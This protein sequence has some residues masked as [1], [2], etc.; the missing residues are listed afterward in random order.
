MTGRAYSNARVR[1]AFNLCSRILI[2]ALTLAGVVAAAASVDAA[3]VSL[4]WNAPTTNA[5]G[6]PLTDLANYRVYLATAAPSCPSPSFL[7]VS[8]PTSTP[9]A[10]QAVAS[11]VTALT[12]GVTYFARITAVDSTGNESSCSPSASGVAQVDFSVTPTATTDFGSVADRWSSRPHIHR[13]EHEPGQHLGDDER[14]K[15]V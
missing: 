12:G 7:T 14:G 9:P 15:P 8:S 4:T 1:T 13:A 3:S 11:R 2:V 6:T 5:D 10:G